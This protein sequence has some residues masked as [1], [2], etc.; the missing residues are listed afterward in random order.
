MA[1]QVK[2]RYQFP[3]GQSL[4]IAQGD[5][6][7][8]DVEAI[9]NAA[10]AMLQHGAGVAGAILRK[11]GPQIQEESDAWVRQHGPITHSR[12]AY[13]HAGRLPFRYII[14]AVGPIWGE[15]D[16]QSKLSAAI[17]GSLQLAEMLGIHSLA[18]PA[19]S[20]GIFGVPKDLAARVFLQTIADYFS[21]SPNSPLSLVRITLYDT[22]TLEVFL[23]TFETWR[24]SQSPTS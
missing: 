17:S 9:V 5:I 19:I 16:E 12:P 13:T 10:N 2:A 4:E 20:T 18:F 8:E 24:K 6:T 15:G 23:E 11:G 21:Q 14:H 7:T 3:G 22:P 1:S